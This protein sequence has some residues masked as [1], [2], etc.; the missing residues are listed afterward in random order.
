MKMKGGWRK[1]RGTGEDGGGERVDGGGGV[2]G[3]SDD[4]L[5]YAKDLIDVL[6]K[7]HKD[8]IYKEMVI[9][10]EACES[11]SIFEGLLS[12]GMNIYVQTASNSIEDSYG[13]YCPKEFG[14]LPFKDHPP[15]REFRTFLGDLYSVSWMEDT[16]LF[17]H[18]RSST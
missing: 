7:K 11:G 4:K 9:Y 10:V 18:G 2:D 8:G 17:S 16:Y 3:L 12:D 13:A 6:K 1:W 14:P 15:P 5:H